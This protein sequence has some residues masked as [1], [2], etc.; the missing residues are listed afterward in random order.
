MIPRKI[1]QMWLDKKDDNAPPPEKYAKGEFCKS[2]QNLNPN[3]E[4]KLWNM[5]DIKQLFQN[6]PLLQK[7]KS[8]WEDK[9]QYHIEKCDFARMVVLYVHGGIYADLDF[10]CHKTLDALI[11]E[12]S[13][14]WTYDILNHSTARNSVTSLIQSTITGVYDNEASIFNG[15]VAAAPE[16]PILAEWMN[17]MMENYK[18]NAKMM[19]VHQTTGPGA[20]GNFA[21]AK[22]YTKKQRPELFIDNAL[23]LPFDS[24]QK[25]R[26]LLIEPFV[27]TKWNEGTDWGGERSIMVQQIILW[28]VVALIVLIV[29]VLLF[30]R[31]FFS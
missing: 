29:A 11:A 17:Y 8:F 19:N 23:I 14:L 25:R 24:Q 20:F 13:F 18:P 26:N 9:L 12:R 21:K 31:L 4:Y 30:Y 28:I 6:E 1:H 7:W 5:A 15:F 10:Y 16:C 22:G 3:Y 2:F 27:S